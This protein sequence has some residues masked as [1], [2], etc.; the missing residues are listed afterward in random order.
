M[1][2][3]TL[4][5]LSLLIFTLVLSADEYT[6][7]SGSSS[8]NYLPIYG[9]FDYGWGKLLYTK[10]ELNDA[11][12][13][14]SARI[15]AIAFDVANSPTFYTLNNQSVYIRHTSASTLNNQYPGTTGFTH[16]LSNNYMF[17]G[18]GW[19]TFS[20]SQEFTWNNQDNLEILWENHDG[21]WANGGP[22]FRYTNTSPSYRGA[23]KHQYSSFP[24]SPGNTTYLRPNIR[25]TAFPFNPPSP[26]VNPDP[27][28]GNAMVGVDTDLQWQNGGGDPTGYR[29]Y[30]GTDPSPL[31]IGDLGL[32]SQWTPPAPLEHAQTYYWQVIPYNGDGDAADCPVWN[33]TTLSDQYIQ[34]GSGIES[35]PQPFGMGY[36]YERSAALYTADQIG[37]SNIIIDRLAWFVRNANLQAAPYVIYAKETEL[38]QLNSVSWDD[39]ISGATQVH[40]G[41]RSFVVPGWSQFL[42]NT[43]F[44]YHD[45]NLIIAVETN[46]GS[47]QGAPSFPSFLYTPSLEPRHQYWFDEV[48]PP[49]GPGVLNYNLPDILLGIGAPQPMPLP[50]AESVS[51][52]DWPSGWTQTQEGEISSPRW[53]V[54]PSGYANGDPNEFTA[55]FTPASSD[56]TSRLISP[57]L[58]TSDESAVCVVFYH[59]FDDYSPGLTASLQYSHDLQSW[60]DSGWSLESGNG[61]AVGEVNISIHD[62]DSP[63]TYLGWTLN[64]DHYSYDYWHVDD[65]MVDTA[66]QID[67]GIVSINAPEVAQPGIFY[68]QITVKNH[69]T[70]TISF[71]ARFT[72]NTSYLQDVQVNDLAPGSVRSVS[73]PPLSID[74][75]TRYSLVAGVI[76]PQDQDLSN[77]LLSADMACVEPRSQASGDV[78]TDPSGNLQGLVN[79]P[80]A[81]PQAM[82]ESPVPQANTNFLTGADHHQGAI[83]ATEYNGGCLTTDR[84]WRISDQDMQLIGHSGVPLNGIASGGP[85]RN[86][87]YGASDTQLYSIDPLTGLATLIGPFNHAGIMIGIAHDHANNI[88]YG[89]DIFYDALFVIDPLTGAATWVGDLGININYT[90][91]CAF[92]QTTGDLY[93]AGYTNHGALYWIDTSDGSAWKIDDFPNGLAIAALAIHPAAAGPELSISTDGVLS[94]EAVDGATQYLIYRADDPYGDF[95]LCGSSSTTQFSDPLWPGERAFYRVSAVFED[96]RAPRRQSIPGLRPHRLSPASN[97]PQSSTLPPLRPGRN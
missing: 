25:F 78:A 75:Y 89:I 36:G 31:L 81:D 9:M 23:Y 3:A 56:G 55:Q 14:S 1:R 85:G 29:L 20:F 13:N 58:D 67:P 52:P 93:L 27:R 38:T 64:G 74:Q 48:A 37:E 90:Q 87:I 91:D 69:G 39:I 68:P 76:H 46:L 45:S 96:S 44:T 26:A 42:L 47:N 57:P 84:V 17:D 11:G 86:V 21:S 34:I 83:I 33:F 6:I 2:K 61:N 12:L 95:T 51:D 41:S 18:S 80:L 7:G 53:Y 50:F 70:A 63:L 88:L 59:Y 24:T 62:L 72:V 30:F 49:S 82:S 60:Y 79:F 77:N 54:S 97:E 28:N 22:S 15:T 94:W 35:Q 40:Q 10:A 71:S 73:F 16:V 92:D 66:P 8:Q 65:V 43:P 5:S 4:L 32:I 19:K